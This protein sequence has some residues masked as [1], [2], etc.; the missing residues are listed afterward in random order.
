MALVT[1]IEM[2]TIGKLF[3]NRL[4]KV[5]PKVKPIF[6]RSTIPEQSKKILMMLSDVISKLDKLEDKI[7]E[8]KKLTQRHTKYGVKEEHYSA[9]GTAV[10]WTPHEGWENIGTMN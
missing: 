6:S 8:V 4:F 10:L 2:E 1:K 3:Y 5:M 9:V 7:D